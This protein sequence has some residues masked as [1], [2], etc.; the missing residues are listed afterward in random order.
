M[1][2]LQNELQKLRQ[3]QGGSENGH[4]SDYSSSLSGLQEQVENLKEQLSEKDLKIQVGFHEG[5]VY[6]L[7]PHELNML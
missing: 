1:F 2:F 5:I 7:L 6:I 4:E 3:N